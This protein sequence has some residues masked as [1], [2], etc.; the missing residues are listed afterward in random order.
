MKEKKIPQT[1]DH[2]TFQGF[3][4]VEKNNYNPFHGFFLVVVAGVFYQQW[5]GGQT[6]MPNITT[7]RLKVISDRTI[8]ETF[9]N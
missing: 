5:E 9:R 2:S 8:C 6:H 7:Y 1:G 4:I 3:W